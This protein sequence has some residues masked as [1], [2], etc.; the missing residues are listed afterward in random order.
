MTKFKLANAPCSWGTIENTKGK[1]IGYRQMLDELAE[2][3]YTGTELGDW[4]FM[5]TD[6]VQLKEELDLRGLELIASWVSVRLY[7]KSFHQDGIKQAIKVAKLLA[8][9]AGQDALI[10]IGDDHSTVKNRYQK[11]GRIS[12]T[13]GMDNET[14]QIYIDGIHKV[15]QAVKDETGLAVSFH[16]HAATYIETPEEI[17]RFL[18]LTDPNLVGLCFDTGHSLLGG[19][20]PAKSIIKYAE[21]IKLIHFKDYSKSIAQDCY[22]KDYN[23]TQMI[24]AGVFSELGQ[25]SVDFKAVLKSLAEINYQGWIVVEQDILPGMGQPLKSAVNNYQYLNTIGI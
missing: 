3:G 8:R 21:R 4:G 24:A 20:E 22:A 6:A 5:P 9:V 1:R 10:N 17:E 19:G 18:A 13:E 2:S 7:D 12:Q 16:P 23:Y 14:W 11:T 15:A 25:G